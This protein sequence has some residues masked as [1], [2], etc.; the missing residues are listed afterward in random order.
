L[1]GRGV[2]VSVCLLESE[3]GMK[4][5]LFLVDCWYVTAIAYRDIL[6]LHFI[7]IESILDGGFFWDFTGN[8]LGF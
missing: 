4:N 8:W 1:D 7:L 3:F 2:E 5:R 6:G